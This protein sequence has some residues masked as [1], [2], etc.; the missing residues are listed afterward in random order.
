MKI[1]TLEDTMTGDKMINCRINI[2]ET[3]N[4]HITTIISQAI[5]KISDEVA[6]QVIKHHLPEILEKI[7]PEAIANMTIASAGEKINTTLN[8]KLP[9]KIL[10]VT[11]EITKTQIYQKGLFGGLKRII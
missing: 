8:K 10:E 6:T 1:E 7:S 2:E 9:D 4:S 3:L 5:D 11:N